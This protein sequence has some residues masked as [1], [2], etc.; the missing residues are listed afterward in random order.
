MPSSERVNWQ[1]ISHMPL[2]ASMIDDALSDTVDHVQTLT[3]ARAQPHV[4][5]DATVSRVERVHREQLEFVD[6]YAEQLRRWRDQRPS[7]AL[8]RELL[9]LEEKNRH[10]RQVTTD[11]LTL[12]TEL[13]K[14]TIDRTIAMSDLERGLQ[15][16]L[17]PPPRGRS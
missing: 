17:G 3:K 6:I 14:G 13:R 1:P 7:A 12:A 9:R 5:D 4:L 11:V 2:V 16:L 15:A 10:L 8:R